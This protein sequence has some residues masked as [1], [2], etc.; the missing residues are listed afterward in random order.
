MT[1]SNRAAKNGASA[2]HAQTDVTPEPS[3]QGLVIGQESRRERRLRRRAARRA[4]MTR[5]RATWVATS[6]DAELPEQLQDRVPGWASTGR[7]RVLL[8]GAA[9]IALLVWSLVFIVIAGL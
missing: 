5:A 3:G 4:R 9:V 1:F 8:A 6:V 2:E 7:G